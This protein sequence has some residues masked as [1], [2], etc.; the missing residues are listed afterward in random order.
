MVSRTSFFSHVSLNLFFF[1][2]FEFKAVAQQ[3]TYTAGWLAGLFCDVSN[4]R[5]RL[6]ELGAT[7][8]MVRVYS[9]FVAFEDEKR[10]GRIYTVQEE[11]RK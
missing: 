10:H 3:W 6:M 1:F 11:K 2:F 4:E 9:V 7:N 8:V 5:K